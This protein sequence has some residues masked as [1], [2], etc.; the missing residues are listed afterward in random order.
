MKLESNLKGRRKVLGIHCVGWDSI[1]LHPH[2][3]LGTH[4]RGQVREPQGDGWGSAQLTVEAA[5][6]VQGID[7]TLKPK[8]TGQRGVERVFHKG[9]MWPQQ[10]GEP[11]VTMTWG[12]LARKAGQLLRRGED[13]RE[14]PTE[15]CGL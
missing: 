11:Q 3:W 10:S 4:S 12:G 5:Y 2:S 15:V 1:H 14:T 8:P 6:T 7:L 9:A 13:R